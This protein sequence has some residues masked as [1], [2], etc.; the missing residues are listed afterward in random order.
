MEEHIE[1]VNLLL[2]LLLVT[3]ATNSYVNY[4]NVSYAV[5][6]ISVTF[7]LYGQWC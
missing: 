7:I 6:R 5:I 3:T 2:L 1:F 4:A